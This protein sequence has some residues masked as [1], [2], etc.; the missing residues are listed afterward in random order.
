MEF[1]EIAETGSRAEGA[2]G[3]L[4]H[5]GPK[6][7][8]I[9]V[10][11]S[12][13]DGVVYLAEKMTHGYQLSTWEHF[14]GRY[15]RYGQIKIAPNNGQF[16]NSDVANRALSEI[17]AR[18]SEEYHLLTDNC[19]SFANRAMYGNPTSGQVIRTAL[20]L[21]VGGVGLWLYANRNSH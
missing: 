3:C 10:G 6:H 19:E 16:K 11:R 18:S 13:S 12:M 5:I 14:I 7:H 15:A 1:T 4:G 20:G 8:A 2:I 21:L 17:A 9:I